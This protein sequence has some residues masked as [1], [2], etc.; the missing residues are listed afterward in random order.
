MNPKKNN[1]GVTKILLGLSNSC[2]SWF[3]RNNNMLNHHTIAKPFVKEITFQK[4]LKIIKRNNMNRHILTARNID[5]YILTSI[6]Y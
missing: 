5:D 4:A 3:K 6:I 2:L 1:Q